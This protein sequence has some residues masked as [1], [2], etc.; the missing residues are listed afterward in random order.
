MTQKNSSIN[1][2]HN[3]CQ[4]TLHHSPE[5]HSTMDAII[6]LL[7]D[8]SS[9]PRDFVVALYADYQTQGRGRHKGR[10]WKTEIGNVIC[11]YALHKDIIPNPITGL[12]LLVGLA[13]L[14][15]L[16]S[17][18]V[19]R[20]ITLKWPND[21]FVDN[22]KV[23][24]ILIESTPTHYIIG[25][26]V[27]V[28]WS[29]DDL[30]SPYASTKI[31]DE[32]QGDRLTIIDGIINNTLCLINQWQTLGFQNIIDSW[33]PYAAYL[34]QDIRIIHTPHV[35]SSQTENCTEQ[36]PPITTGR[37]IGLDHNGGICVKTET[38]D[39]VFYAGDVSLRGL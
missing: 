2:V 34:N 6:P 26:G 23:A 16:E 13:V 38:G 21:V 33:I 32:I 7:N 31:G 39:H 36:S 8:T 24:G 11:S 22:K 17:L 10:I 5:I 35:S 9:Q 3:Q 30:D 4:Y 15:T 27:N 12:S 19:K 18:G 37:F 14:S 25:V 29:P 20:P 28:T 1:G